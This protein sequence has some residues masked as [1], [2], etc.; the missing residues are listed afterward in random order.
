MVLIYSFFEI[1]A[2]F[3]ESYFSFRFNDLFVSQEMPKKKCVI[4][5]AIL[6]AIIYSINFMNLF[7]ILT[8]LIALLF[9]S[10]TNHFLFKVPLFDTFSITAFFSFYMIFFDFFSMAIIG[11]FL[12][13]NKFAADVV[14]IQSGYR[15]IFLFVSKSL[16]V[17]SYLMVRGLLLHLKKLKSRSLL[18]IT[19]LGY[20]GICYY[21]KI[22]FSYIDFNVIVSWLLLFVIIIL[23][24]FSLLAYI[25]YQK[26]FAQKKLIEV[27]N[28][29]IAENYTDLAR[30]YRGNAQLYHDMKNHILILQNLFKAK[31]YSEAEKYTNSLSE[32]ASVLDYTWTGSDIIDCILNIKKTV[33][34]QMNITLMIDVD[35]IGVDLDGV[36]VS[37]IIS[38]LLDNA[39]EACQKFEDEIPC[40]RVAIRH[41]ND[42]IF[43]K[44]QNPAYDV[45]NFEK[46]ILVTTKENGKDQHGWGLKSVEAAVK[47][48]DGVFRYSCNK[49]KFTSVVTLF[50]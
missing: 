5:S 47:K 50:L 40:I 28:N 30:S 33:C 19:I 37:T 22:T 39:I 34:E 18:L 23:A 38:N 42:M 16:L 36:I 43:I 46:G 45:S 21:A 11:F 35:P 25:C 41:I 20:F 26:E 48:V 15:C 31:N 14:A 27:R 24:L 3:V 49:G 29:V 44:I 2:T 6:S 7:S 13:D 4:M 9:V 10:T 12:G 17:V 1:V 32:T 8:L